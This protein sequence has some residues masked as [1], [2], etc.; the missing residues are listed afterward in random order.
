MGMKPDVCTHTCGLWYKACANDFFTFD[1]MSGYMV[2]C[3]A[4]G[5]GIGGAPCTRVSDMAANG[6]QFCDLAGGVGERGQ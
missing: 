5:P 3:P 4:G 1:A 2:P 6:T